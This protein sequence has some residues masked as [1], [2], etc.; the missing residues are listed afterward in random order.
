MMP[1]EQE[2]LRVIHQQF[3]ATPEDKDLFARIAGS[4]S[5][6][7]EQILEGITELTGRRGIAYGLLALYRQQVN[8]GFVLADPL[9]PEGKETKRFLDKTCDVE[10]R[11]LWNPDR[12]LRK[13]H[14][15][16]IERG[17]IAEHVDQARLINRD[18]HGKPCYLCK[19]NIALQSPAEILLPLQLGG[20]EYLLG[21]N[22]A[23]IENNHFT[24]MSSEHRDQRYRKHILNVLNDFVERT[25][26]HFRAI[27]NGLAGASI[28][29]HEHLQVTSV[30]FPIEAIR[31]QRYDV[32]VEANGIRVS[33]PFYYTPLWVVEGGCR[34]SVADAAHRVIVTWHEL[35][36]KHHTENVIASRLGGTFRMF[37]FLRDIRRLA[38]EGKFGDMASFECG[39]IIVLSYR[40]PPRGPHET[41]ERNTFESATLATVRRLLADIAPVI[42]D[43]DFA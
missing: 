2:Y 7:R 17:V 34:R 18:K 35:N 26:G 39:G 14:A 43:V 41:D 32:V 3:N 19:E 38:G 23:Y 9:G 12:E 29:W 10:F 6:E 5:G 36:P 20:E 31:I 33:Q 25:D 13:N 21:A 37:I 27:F 11:L 28:P 24:V 40:P 42:P 1:M 30:S 4:P 8:C 16:L 22:F 15:L